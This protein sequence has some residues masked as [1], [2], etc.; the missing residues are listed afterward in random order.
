MEMQH[1]LLATT[2]RNYGNPKK[3]NHNWE[4]LIVCPS[5][6]LHLSLASSYLSLHPIHVIVW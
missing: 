5:I 3:H 1:L 4:I 2:V 6:T